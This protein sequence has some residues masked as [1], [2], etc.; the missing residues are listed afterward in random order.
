[1]TERV[2]TESGSVYDFD[3]DFCTVRRANPGRPKRRDDEV[4]SLQARPEIA[5]G[6]RMVLA[7]EPLGGD[8]TDV[9]VRV[10]TPVVSREHVDNA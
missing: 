6:Q 7:L 8:G 5:V 2:V 4:L 3:D 9:T 10:T 1:M